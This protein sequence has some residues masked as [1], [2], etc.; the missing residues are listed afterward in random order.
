MVATKRHFIIYGL[1]DPITGQLRYIGKSINGIKRAKDHTHPSSILRNNNIHFK[2]WLKSLISKDLKPQ[3]DILEEP[4]SIEDL[5]E[6]E[7]FH[8]ASV[9]ASG[10]RLL[11]IL[12]GGEDTP[13]RIWSDEA[14]LARSIKYTGVK[15]LSR[16]RRQTSEDKERNRLTGQS[17]WNVDKDQ[18]RLMRLAKGSKPFKDQYDNLYY[19]TNEL[20]ITL[21]VH[22]SSVKDALK[23][24]SKTVKGLVL[25]Y[26]DLE[27][28]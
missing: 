1:I 8:I 14:K 6:L 22:K 19:S 10:A 25:K 16:G 2:N 23:G 27:N 21:G 3:I 28:I 15:C 24:R 12:D 9:R 18:I 20:A 4:S 7:A 13:G 26:I 17:Y 5:N 11:N